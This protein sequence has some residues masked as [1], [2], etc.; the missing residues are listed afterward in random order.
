MS[1]GYL[2][3]SLNKN[4]KITYKNLKDALP[5]HSLLD[6]SSCETID[7]IVPEHPDSQSKVQGHDLK[8][9][10]TWCCFCVMK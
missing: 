5:R 7:G 4:N 1:N 3:D 10:V 9:D 2:I 6:N 8:R